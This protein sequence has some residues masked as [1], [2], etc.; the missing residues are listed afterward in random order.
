M[1]PGEFTDRTVHGMMGGIEYLEDVTGSGAVFTQRQ[2]D[3]LSTLRVRLGVLA[4]CQLR[5]QATSASLSRDTRHRD[6]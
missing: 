1:N 6:N 2:S 3:L 4:Q 5:N